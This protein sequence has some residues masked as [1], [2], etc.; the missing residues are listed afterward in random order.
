MLA[1]S[2][3][4]VQ[5]FKNIKECKSGDVIYRNL[6]ACVWAIIK[7]TNILSDSRIKKCID[8]LQ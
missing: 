2:V 7:C 4:D 5:N 3:I 1:I 8:K 6:E